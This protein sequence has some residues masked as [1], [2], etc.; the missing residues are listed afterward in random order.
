MTQ[1]E[2]DDISFK[3]SKFKDLFK[4]SVKTIALFNLEESIKK[5]IEERMVH[6]E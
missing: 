6:I 3:V 4:G 1:E 5:K 2:S